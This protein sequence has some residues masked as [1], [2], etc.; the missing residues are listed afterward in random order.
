MRMATQFAKRGD[1][2]CH[3]SLCRRNPGLKARFGWEVKLFR[4]LKLLS[5]QARFMNYNRARGLFSLEL[6]W[7]PERTHDKLDAVQIKL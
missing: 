4:Q 5:A 6:S 2:V 3:V 7:R 1:G